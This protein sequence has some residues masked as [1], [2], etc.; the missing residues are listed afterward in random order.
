MSQ[1]TIAILGT[2]NVGAGLGQALVVAG[3]E[4]IFGS[5]NPDQVKDLPGKLVAME[6]A[7]KSSEIV[8]L[9]VPYHTLAELLPSLK[10]GLVGK[11]VVDL[12]NPLKS[13]MSGLVTAADKSGAEIVQETLPDSM[14][15]KALNTI[16]ASAYANSCQVH[17]DSISTF[18]AGNDAEAKSKVSQFCQTIGLDVV[19]AGDISSARMI[20]SL[21]YLNIKLAFMLNMGPEI[22]FKLM[23]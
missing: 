13:D 1:N 5:R 15:V 11:I 23:R 10:E 3:Y 16:F 2:G 8:V 22:G 17:G 21:A 6:V 19:D 20:E 9:S 14:I 12:T 7:V 4:V 18:L